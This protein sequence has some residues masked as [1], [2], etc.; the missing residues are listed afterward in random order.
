MNKICCVIAARNESRYLPGFLSHVGP[1]VH[2]IIGLDDGS[3]DNTLEIFQRSKY[4]SAVLT[5][6][7]PEFA[8]QHETINRHRLLME[9]K[10]QGATWVLYGDADERFEQEFLEA[11]GAHCHAGD[12]S[13]EVVRFFRLVNLWNSHVLYRADGLCGPR[14]APRMFK[15]PAA[16]QIRPDNLLH[17]PW[18]PPELDTKPKAQMD[19]FVFHLRMIEAEDRLARWKKFKAIDPDNQHQSIGYDHLIN[20]RGLALEAIT[21][22][23]GYRLY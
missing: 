6:P 19:A 9:A 21:R 4:V 13:G 10:R 2:S 12:K 7:A 23:R 17:R 22:G 1:Y 11:I 14:W 16:F 8:H 5:G 20:E 15:V 18:Y 3:S